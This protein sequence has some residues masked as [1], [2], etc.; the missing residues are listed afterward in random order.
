MAE[1]K[2]NQSRK[3]APAQGSSKKKL[4]I[5]IAIVVLISIGASIGVTLFFLKWRQ[6]GGIQRKKPCLPSQSK[7]G[8][9]LRL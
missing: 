6:R 4:I 7:S 8:A 3:K 2:Q 5:I 9:V 1:K